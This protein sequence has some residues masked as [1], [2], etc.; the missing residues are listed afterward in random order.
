MNTENKD[1]E[2]FLKDVERHELIVI[3]DNG[4]DRH[5][6]FKRPG[7]YCMHFDLITWPGYLCYTG[8]MG[9]YVFQRLD[10]MFEFFRTDRKGQTLAINPSYWGQKLQA[11]DSGD[12]FKQYSHE[13]FCQLIN[14]LVEQHIKDD[15]LT[16][17]EAKELKAEV[18]SQVLG[19]EEYENAA[20]IAASDFEYEG[21][22]FSDFWE[23]D[24][25]DYSYRFMWCCRALAWGINKYDE[26]KA[27]S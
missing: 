8:D 18:E 23:H 10:D 14:E 7:S 20:Y 15:E 11:V 5:I 21:F 17:G 6:R 13:K 3:R 4:V 16:P 19:C 22:E 24:L 9:T 26:T 25:K 27:G 12:G 2:M 1:E